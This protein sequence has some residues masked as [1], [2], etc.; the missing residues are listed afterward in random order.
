MASLNNF[1]ITSPANNDLIIYSNG[2]WINSNMS[3]FYGLLD[4]RYS[5]NAHNHNGVYAP[6]GASYLKAE[7]YPAASLYTKAELYTKTEIDA[8][9]FGGGGSGSGTITSGTNLGSGTGIFKDVSGSSLR[10]RSLVSSD[11]SINANIVGDTVDL[12][13]VGT[14]IKSL[15]NSEDILTGR[16]SHGEGIF[17]YNSRQGTTGQPSGETY[18]SGIVWG[19]GTSGS[20]EL[21]G[22]WVSGNWGKLWVR[23]LRDTTDN[24]SAWYEVY[25]SRSDIPWSRLTSVPAQATRWPSWSEVNSQSGDQLD[26]DKVKADHFLTTKG[27]STGNFST[28]G[29]IESGRGS[30]GVA[31]TIND[32]KGNANVTW[33]HAFGSPEQDGNAA[34]IEVNTDSTSGA[35]FSFELGSGVTKDVD[36]NLNQAMYLSESEFRVLGKD[37]WRQGTVGVGVGL[38]V[39]YDGTGNPTLDLSS[40]ISDF[41]DGT[42]SGNYTFNGTTTF[43]GSTNFNQNVNLNSGKHLYV[44][45]GGQ[46]KFQPDGQDEVRINGSQGRLDVYN[47]TDNDFAEVRAKQL[48][49]SDTGY[50]AAQVGY[51][52]GSTELNDNETLPSGFFTTSAGSGIGRSGTWQHVLNFHHNDDNGFNTQISLPF[53]SADLRVRHSSGDVFSDWK[54][55]WTEGNDGPGSGLNADLLDGL[56]ASQFLRSDADDSVS[57][58]I[59]LTKSTTSTLSLQRSSSTAYNGIT[60]GTQGV[61]GTQYILYQNNDAAANLTLQSRLDNGTINSVFNHDRL[62]SILNFTCETTFSKP[63]SITSDFQVGATPSLYATT[64]EV[65]VRSKLRVDTIEDY[66]NGTINVN[67]LL[68]LSGGGLLFEGSK[69]TINY[70]DGTGNFNIKVGTAYGSS[71]CT[72][73]GYG[74]HWVFDQNGGI[75]SFR[76]SDG[77]FTSG[78]TYSWKTPLYFTNSTVYTTTSDIDTLL[79]RGGNTLE[80]TNTETRIKKPLYVDEIRCQGGTRITIG[81]GELG[82]ELLAEATSRYPGTGSEYLHIGGESG[83]VMWSSPDNM[84][85]GPAGLHSVKLLDSNGKTTLKMLD[86]NPDGDESNLN[87]IGG[88]GRYARAYYRTSDHKFGFYMH[89]SSGGIGTRLSWDGS[90]DRWTA[91]GEMWAPDMVATSDIRFKTDLQEVDN[92][93]DKV[94]QLTGYTYV[95]TELEQRKAGVIAQDLQKVLPEGVIEDPDGKLGV[96]P[97]A[98]TALLVNAIKEQQDQIDELKE[99]VKELISNG[100]L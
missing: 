70:N 56:E 48:Y 26:Y 91:T 46:V 63:V 57:G 88:N 80:S 77:G 65:Q 38:S 98:T 95:Q 1:N 13:F 54:K 29:N 89:N 36:V 33:N 69:H 9:V 37:V 58:S 6:V 40:N 20:V 60:W 100:D 92:A 17:T 72:E 61:Y 82:N 15:G 51:K 5:T 71:T 14:N 24:W 28:S 22:G 53:G 32:G 99:L 18:G 16:N 62:N 27:N 10:F 78:Q 93:V 23:G 75:W 55:I 86:I 7:T 34:R 81:A 84:G 83:I 96:S 87:L 90:N 39:S 73:D 12:T 85:S 94:K 30:G 52:E 43:G 42:T 35:A 45:G 3:G 76:I 21:W 49:I 11:S 31:L 2:E 19:Q 74:S 66:D 4:G 67:N 8:M 25:T 47:Q 64:S 59:T 97:H 68:N 44:K 41:S 50:E 79:V